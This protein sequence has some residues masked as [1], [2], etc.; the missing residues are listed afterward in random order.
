MSVWICDTCHFSR[1]GSSLRRRS[2]REV[3]GETLPHLE[4]LCESCSEAFLDIDPSWDWQSEG[5]SRAS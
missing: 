4:I 5:W 3:D 1:I 2:P